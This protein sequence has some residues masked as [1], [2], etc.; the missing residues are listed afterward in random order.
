MAEKLGRKEAQSVVDCMLD[1]AEK[2]GFA[3]AVAVV[4]PAGDL[5]AFGRTGRC[6]PLYP[7]MAVIKAHTAATWGQDTKWL[8][9]HVVKTENISMTWFGNPPQTAILGGVVLR[10]SDGTILGA[11]GES[12]PPEETDEELARIGEAHFKAL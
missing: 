5:I 6:V 11:I 8:R 10:A 12:G 3:F 4:D 2:R 9:E 7:R 1:E